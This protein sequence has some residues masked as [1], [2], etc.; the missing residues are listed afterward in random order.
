MVPAKT[1]RLIQIV[2]VS[3]VVN[4]KAHYES[5]PESVAIIFSR[6]FFRLRRSFDSS[7]Y[8]VKAKYYQRTHPPERCQTSQSFEIPHLRH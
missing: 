6:I 5:D 1:S 3:S 8:F 7:N 4:E 2:D